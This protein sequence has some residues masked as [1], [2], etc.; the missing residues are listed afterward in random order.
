M[1]LPPDA[2]MPLSLFLCYMFD[3]AF[4]VAA[5]A[6]ALRQMFRCRRR[7]AT[8]MRCT[9]RRHTREQYCTTQLPRMPLLRDAA[10][11]MRY[12]RHC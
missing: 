9:C 7:Y 12:G 8:L 2:V 1:L 10:I 11:T 6:K 4:Y 3:I 5:A